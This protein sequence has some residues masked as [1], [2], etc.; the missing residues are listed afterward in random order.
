MIDMPRTNSSAVVGLPEML[1]KAYTEIRGVLDNLRQSRN[2]IEQATVE[3][4]HHTSAKLLEVSSATEVAATGILD[5]LDRAIAVVDELDGM[6]GA[7]QPNAVDARNRLRDEL[8]AVQ[9]C[10]QFQDI[11]NQQLAHASSLLV[12]MEERLV[13]LARTLDPNMMDEPA[14]AIEPAPHIELAFDPNATIDGAE[15]RQALADSIF[16]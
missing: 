10:V 14:P 12:D 6:E 13:G 9:A 8:F 5:G 15:V 2:V 11:T 3:K 1:L 16:N 7:T 4:L